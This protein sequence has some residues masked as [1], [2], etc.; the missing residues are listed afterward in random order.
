MDQTLW[1]EPQRALWSRIGAMNIDAPGELRDAVRGP[2]ARG[3]SGARV[4]LSFT[5]RLARENGWSP[6]FA[7]RVEP[8]Y[9]RFLFLAMEAGHPVTPSEE[10][11][12]AWHLHLAYTRSYWE[13][14]CVNV[15]PRALHHGPTKGGAAE[16]AKFHDWYART[17]ESYRRLFGDEPPADIWPAA[18]ERFGDAA[19]YRRVNTR[20][21]LV[22]PKR[23]LGVAGAVLGG[24][25]LLAAM[26]GC[27]VVLAQ[28]S[29]STTGKGL[30]IFAGV[31]GLLLIIIVLAAVLRG[32]GAGGRRTDAHA[33]SNSG[34][35]SS[36]ASFGGAGCGSSHS[37]GDAGTGAGGDSSGADSGSSGCGSSGCSGGGCGS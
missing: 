37:K 32:A 19:H 15:L 30:L 28:G 9:R 13:D 24:G 10:V 18:P 21:H 36:G 22:M 3:V 34:G 14:L 35:C 25:A 5:R 29:V 27:G 2:S 23:A 4:A 7:Q 1:T 6:G 26:G 16:D 20:T 12:Q 11:D 17:I 31:V 33:N 8:E